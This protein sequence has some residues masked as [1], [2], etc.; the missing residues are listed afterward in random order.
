MKAH[1]PPLAHAISEEGGGRME[2]RW[3]RDGGEMEEG[4]E[5]MEG[6]EEWKETGKNGEKQG[7]TGKNGA[8]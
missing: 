7:K 6:E 2:E 1:P 8:K 5:G 3:R 4:G